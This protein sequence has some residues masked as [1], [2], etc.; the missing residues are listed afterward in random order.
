MVPGRFVPEDE[1]EPR[2][3]IRIL[4]NSV[5]LGTGP[6]CVPQSM[7]R[8]VTTSR[9]LN[10]AA[11]ARGMNYEALVRQEADAYYLRNCDRQ[12]SS[13]GDPVLCEVEF[14]A[15]QD[16]PK[17]VLEIGC[18]S[19]FRLQHIA[20]T[21]GSACH[22]VEASHLAVQSGLELHPAISFTNGVAPEALRVYPNQAFDLVIVGFM[23]YLLPR[24]FEFALA[25]E[26]DRITETWGRVIVLDF[27]SPVTMARG[28]DHD[29]QL[30]TYK[31][32][33]SLLLHWN[34]RWTLM[35]RR[36]FSHGSASPA[37]RYHPDEWMSVDTLIKLPNN[38]A[39]PGYRAD[40]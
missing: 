27:M 11:Y 32:D 4:A 23:Q 31:T 40:Q 20:E 26:I 15:P 7:S 8:W 13:E 3:A 18:A 36:S 9:D 29:P 37:Q 33:P 19:G 14:W 38:V 34:P 28:Y 5:T 25:A 16:P 35:S 1:D 10:G 39:Y 30:V 24:E 22:G 6:D 17:Q 2:S 21:Y 12:W